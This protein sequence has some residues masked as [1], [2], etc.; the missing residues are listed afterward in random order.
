MVYRLVR[1]PVTMSS[2]H[3]VS[4][5]GSPV[6]RSRLIIL[7][8]VVA[9]VS[10]GVVIVTSLA[11]LVFRIGARE[12]GPA[13]RL[14]IVTEGATAVV[15]P[16][17]EPSPDTAPSPDGVRRSLQ[18]AVIPLL[19]SDSALPDLL[20]FNQNLTTRAHTLLYLNSTDR[21][22]RWES[23]PLSEGRSQ[24]RLVPGRS[25]IY[26][27]AQAEL[28]ALDRRE[29]YLVWRA[30]LSNNLPAGC[31]DCL[32][33]VGDNVVVLTQD[34]VLQSFDPQSGEQVWRQ[35]LL[36]TPRQLL[37]IGEQVAVMDRLGAGRPEAVLHVFDPADGTLV[38]RIE[39]V[40][41]DPQGFFSDSYPG[42][43]T[44]VFHLP[45]RQALYL[46][47]GTAN[48]CAQLVSEVNGEVIWRTNVD[49]L[50]PTWHNNTPLI[51]DAAVHIGVDN[52]IVAFAMDD[53]NLRRLTDEPDYDFLPLALRDGTLVVEATRTRGARRTELWGIDAESG[54]PRWRYVLEN[55]RG[56]GADNWAWHLTPN[57]VT[58]MQKSP[59]AVSIETLDIREG[60]RVDQATIRLEDRI[61]IWRGITIIDDIAYLTL[62]RLYA[63]DLTTGE[64]VYTWPAVTR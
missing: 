20:V 18:G 39:P 33:V 15:E 38:R 5:K 35:R 51:T 6:D 58:V 27:A 11:L 41:P 57:G 40:C 1:H 43:D 9:V 16:T 55:E 29:G 24:P 45:E 52:R 30:S 31:R 26:L 13:P 56:T 46:M 25:M 3:H 17:A 37:V 53:G 47:F 48:S 61:T 7:G 54:E 64:V 59:R 8:I 19:D 14:P 21:T 34:G 23:A 50:P 12:V 32:R 60:T 28:L 10:L 4:S 49:D 22:I 42:I 36:D 2:C 62:Q 63:I 44:P